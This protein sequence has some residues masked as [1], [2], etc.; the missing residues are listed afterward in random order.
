MAWE[1]KILY[2]GTSFFGNHAFM[3]KIVQ[4]M[5]LQKIKYPTAEVV[6]DRTKWKLPSNKPLFPILSNLNSI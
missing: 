1:G 3:A 5:Y 6:P 4:T 2:K